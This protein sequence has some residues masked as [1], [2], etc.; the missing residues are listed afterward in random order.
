[1]FNMFKFKKEVKEPGAEGSSSE[2]G[3]EIRF[4]QSEK[5]KFIGG[6]SADALRRALKPKQFGRAPDDNIYVRLED[7]R[8]LR[9]P[10]TTETNAVLNDLV[11]KG[12]ALNNKG[13]ERELSE[14]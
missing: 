2:T 3:A 1:M 11:L 9:A 12:Y 5:Y 10:W 7:G 6:K 13:L 14:D 8:F 4:L